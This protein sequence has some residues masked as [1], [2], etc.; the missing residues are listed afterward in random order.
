VGLTPFARRETDV[1]DWVRSSAQELWRTANIRRVETAGIEASASRSWR[2]G[3]VRA[4]YSWIDSAAP[5]LTELSKYIADYAR[6]SLAVAAGAQLGA[7]T[8][9]GV[10]S[11]C[12]RKIDGRAYCGA[13]LRASRRVGTIELLFDATNLFDVRYQEVKGVDM[14]PRTL[15]AGVRIGR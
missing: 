4:E 1:I 12:K 3:F 9:L 8:S 7:R 6:H 15:S 10:R 2:G 5:A 13:D 11:D 14:P